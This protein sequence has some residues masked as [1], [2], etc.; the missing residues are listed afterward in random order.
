M[1]EPKVV[2]AT[3]ILPILEW[4]DD[5]FSAGELSDDLVSGDDADPDGD[6][7]KN[8]QEYLHMSDP[9]NADSK[10]LVRTQVDGGYLS[11]IFTRNAG[12]SGMVLQCQGSR[13]LTSW[14]EPALEER[15]IGSE[16]GIHTVE[17]RLPTTGQS[18]GFMRFQY[19][20]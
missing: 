20:R 15:I 5:Y 2:Y 3:F 6:G 1:D 12:A 9:R 16:N 13:D 18:S 11:T 7:L 14:D 19:A 17:A 10:G 4:K 8:W